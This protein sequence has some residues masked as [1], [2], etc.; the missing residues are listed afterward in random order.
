MRRSTVLINFA[1]TVDGKLAT[2]GH[3]SATPGD[4]VAGHHHAGT[5]ARGDAAMARG[6]T[7]EMGHLAWAADDPGLLGAR[8]QPSG[9]ALQ[10]IISRSGR[11]GPGL[12][13]FAEAFGP[14]VVF[15]A[16][17]EAVGPRLPARAQ[18]LPLA[19]GATGLTTILTTLH[20]D[21]GV[22][23]VACLGGPTLIRTFAEAD[24]I[25]EIHLTL[26]P[27]LAGGRRWPGLLGDPLGG[28]LPESRSFR[29]RHAASEDGRAH[30]RYARRR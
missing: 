23:T 11:L 10:V 30:L 6:V 7:S 2:A 14:T 22:R 20:T 8:G 21:Y 29:L 16:Q 25:D 4:W 28:F 18:V 1:V 5:D 13:G 27:A 26:V 17:P 19:E 3:P 9:D 24:L 15:T 12:P